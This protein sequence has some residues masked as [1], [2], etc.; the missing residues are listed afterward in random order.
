VTTR[1]PEPPATPKDPFQK[2]TAAPS[3]SDDASVWLVSFADDD[4]RE[5]GPPEI[6]AALRRGEIRAETIVWREGMADWAAIATVPELAR[7]LASSGETAG[8]PPVVNEGRTLPAPSP[9]TMTAAK[10]GQASLPRPGAPRADKATPAAAGASKDAVA[11]APPGAAAEPWKGKTRLGLP[12]IGGAAGAKAEEQKNLTGPSAPQ[13]EPGA[14]AAGPSGA[15]PKKFEFKKAEPKKFEFKKAEPKTGDPGKTDPTPAAAATAP[16]RSPAAPRVEPSPVAPKVQPA[17]AAPK[18]EPSPVAPAVRPAGAA[19]E[20]DEEPISIDPESIRPLMPPGVGRAMAMS[21]GTLSVAKKSPPT[22]PKPPV[23]KRGPARAPADGGPDGDGMAIQALAAPLTAASERDD[24]DFLGVGGS[25]PAMLAAPTI[26]FSSPLADEPA[27]GAAHGVFQL[28]P[29]DDE[30][31]TNRLGGDTTPTVPV[32]EARATA[33]SAATDRS[34]T[35]PGAAKKRSLVPFVIGGAAAAVAITLALRGPG[36][37]K[38][39]SRAE[40]STQ[41]EAPRTAEPAAPPAAPAAKEEAPPPAPEPP[42]SAAPAASALAAPPAAAAA[43]VEP[44][45]AAGA[46]PP[47]AP[48]K[49][50]PKPEDSTTKVA[51][52]SR[53]EPGAAAATRSVPASP[54]PPPEAKAAAAPAPPAAPEPTEVNV[55]GEFDK[56]AAT[57]ALGAAAAEA[58]GCRKEGDPSGIATVHVTFSNAGRATRA[59]LEGPPF[60]GTPTGGCI[61]AALRKAKIPPYGGDRVTVTKRVVIN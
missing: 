18:V 26:N 42:T 46:A 28:P 6:A 8:L 14:K 38:P 39:E 44:P 19:A 4:D 33:K 43:P 47:E 2:A 25:G 53:T 7:L 24:M 54:A 1:D 23:P 58:S 48:A 57:A 34:V 20:D 61:T 60:G 55:G 12:K 41:Q 11:A 51:G 40:P 35:P 59:T 31:A 30:P 45:K 52:S 56:A 27:A 10:T 37:D 17:G 13:V 49:A 21:A 32:S 16:K 29:L 5:L 9:T 3:G 15:E 50:A 36:G 22:A